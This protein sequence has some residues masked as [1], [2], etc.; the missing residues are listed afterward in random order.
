MVIARVVLMDGRRYRKNV[1]GEGSPLSHRPRGCSRL[2][3]RPTSLPQHPDDFPNLARLERT[4]GGRV[5]R[6]FGLTG[7]SWQ[8]RQFR[9]QDLEDQEAIEAAHSNASYFCNRFIIAQ[10]SWSECS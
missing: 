8:R 3:G 2:A 5:D 10:T 6:S 4:G 7:A 1:I 9:R